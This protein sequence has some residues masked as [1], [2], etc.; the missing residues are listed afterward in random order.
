VTRIERDKLLGLI[1]EVTIAAEDVGRT[2][3]YVGGRHH[4][5]AMV[6]RKDALDDLL[7]FI[8][9]VTGYIA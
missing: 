7:A 6:A 5:T 8:D 9:Q 3:G 1:R 2:A 4:R